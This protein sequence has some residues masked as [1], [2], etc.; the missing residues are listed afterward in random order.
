MSQGEQCHE[1]SREEGAR[2]CG[3]REEGARGCGKQGGCLLSRGVRE[4]L[5]EEVT[6]GQR[7]GG[8]GREPCE[9]LLPGLPSKG[10]SKREGSGS[11]VRP[12]HARMSKSPAWLQQSREGRS[13]S[14]RRRAT[15]GPAG[16]RGG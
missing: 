14:G 1:E 5:T 13:R 8:G 3:C 4:G 6:R 9:Y 12:A 10:I 11:R 7:P 2:G 15:W 16:H